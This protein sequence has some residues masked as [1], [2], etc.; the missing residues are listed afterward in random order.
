MWPTSRTL[1]RHGRVGVE[2]K[3]WSSYVFEVR[4]SF[5]GETNDRQLICSLAQMASLQSQTVI[6]EKLY[7]TLSHTKAA[8]ERLE[9]LTHVGD[10]SLMISVTMVWELQAFD[11]LEMLFS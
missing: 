1:P 9:K 5:A 7:K 2:C 6:R 8:R 3:R 10:G 4:P 11:I